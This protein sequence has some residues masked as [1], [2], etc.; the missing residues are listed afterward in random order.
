MNLGVPTTATTPATASANKTTTSTTNNTHRLLLD[1]RSGVGYALTRLRLLSPQVDHLILRQSSS[2]TTHMMRWMALPRVYLEQDQLLEIF[3]A[4]GKLN[5]LRTIVISDFED[6]EDGDHDEHDNNGNGNLPALCLTLL[7]QEARELTALR[8]DSNR[9][10][11]SRSQFQAL[12]KAL[13][14]H[15]A[16]EEICF[17][18]CSVSIQ[19]EASRTQ[20]T[21]ITYNDNRNNINNTFEPLAAAIASI[22]TLQL[23]EISETEIPSSWTGA[24][25]RQFCESK[26][27]QVLRIRGGR[28][29]GDQDIAQM[30]NA[31][32]SNTILKELWILSCDFRLQSRVGPE[33]LAKMLRVNTSLEVLGLNRLS[34]K[35]HA[36]TIAE[37]LHSNTSL[38]ALHLCLRDGV[39]NQICDSYAK[40]MEDNYVLEKMSGGFTTNRVGCR[41]KSDSDIA[42]LQ[43][44][45]YLKLNRNGRRFLL[46][47]E[48]SNRTQWLNALCSQK[49]DLSAV[50]YL[51]SKNPSL[52]LSA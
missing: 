41:G 42:A 10:V 27:L 3:Q 28:F 29:L 43:I 37:A 19:V 44:D 36:I 49:E 15:P 31:L 16:L 7:L 4:I 5:H 23:V 11:G 26:Y 35:E 14:S 30:V 39:N 52:F 38:R 40:L 17:T 21:R 32:Q 50:F 24:S 25:L 45:F 2:A 20:P 33:A 18:W 13:Q 9:I 12:A 47:H 34:G 8:L 6:D 46:Q 1:L 22:P 48:N 51:L